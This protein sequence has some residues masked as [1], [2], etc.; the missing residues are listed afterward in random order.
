[1]NVLTLIK[2]VKLHLTQQ[3][4]I[5]ILSYIG[6]EFNR[7]GK[8]K[9]RKDENTASAI[10]NTSGHIK[11]YGSGWYG[12]IIDVLKE[13]HGLSTLD[14]TIYVADCIGVDYE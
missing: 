7:Y 2:E 1:M 6:Y 14:A 11:D 9:L 3:E 13:F 8:F 4:V 12:D 5:R 10:V